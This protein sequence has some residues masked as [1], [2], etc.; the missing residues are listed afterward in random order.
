[1]ERVTK[2]RADVESML[3]SV[4]PEACATVSDRCKHGAET[5][6]PMLSLKVHTVL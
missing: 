2:Q 6:I 5:H 4:P 3:G 1:M